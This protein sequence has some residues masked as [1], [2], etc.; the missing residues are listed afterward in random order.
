MSSIVPYVPS[1]Y[2]VIKK[3]LE[4]AGLKKGELFLDPGCGDGRSLVMAAKD[5]G[6]RAVGIEIRKDLL[7]R[8]LKNVIE[9]GVSDNVLL[10]NGNFF[11][12][13]F[14]QAD[15]VFLYLLTS[16]NEKLKP[17]LQSEL[18][19][20]TRIVSHD[21]EITGWKPIRVVEVREGGRSHKIYY[22]IVGESSRQDKHPPTY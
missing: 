3:A 10:I 1:P 20:T 14:P 22:Y 6:A 7:E 19:P 15:V 16:V 2:E 21:F 18:K 4:I 9:A 11:D 12:V 5:F 13:K 17:K 8:A